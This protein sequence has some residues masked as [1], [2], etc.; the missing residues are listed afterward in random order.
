MNSGEIMSQVKISTLDKQGL[1][2]R[3]TLGAYIYLYI[4]SIS[5][6]R[7]PHRTD[8][9]NT[10]VAVLFSFGNIIVSEYP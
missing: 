6:S 1:E 3:G 4:P 5:W 8:T 7:N 10:Q 9:A 2:T